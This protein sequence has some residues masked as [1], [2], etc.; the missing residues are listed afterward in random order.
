MYTKEKLEQSFRNQFG[1]K[2][3]IYVKS[4]GRINIIG[5]HTDYNNG[6]VMPAAIDKYIYIA[7]SKRDDDRVSLFSADYNERYTSELNDDTKLAP[8]WAKYIIGATIILQEQSEILTGFNLFVIGDVPLGAGLSSSAAFSCA[9]VFAINELY[10]LGF[11]RIDIAKIGQRIE[12]EFI[13]VKCGLMD[14]FASV[15]GKSNHAIKLDCQDLSYEYIPIDWSSYDLL[16]LNTNVK[17]SLASSA[18]NDRRESCEK[19]VA[20]VKA[21]IPDVKSLRD[22]SLEQLEKYVFAKDKDVYYKC[23]FVVE[24]NMRLQQAAK[25]LVE[26]DF[27]LLG[28][29]LFEAHWALSKEYEVSCPELDYLIQ[30]A[31]SNEYVVGA[32]MMG[33]GFGGCTINIIQKGKSQDFVNQVESAYEKKFGLAISPIYIKLS[34][35]TSIIN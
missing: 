23:K 9:T 19:G 24:E 10:D 17:H 33:G 3:D 32:R 7:L 2:A 30:V 4:P 25:A 34:D 31:Q 35:G 20:W 8:E 27:A 1:V 21:H 5:E 13:G 12:H 6:F 22:I 14:Q 11:S 18:Y 26:N 15:M 29:L 28:K 16:L